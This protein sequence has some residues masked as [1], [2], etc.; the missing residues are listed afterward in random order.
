MSMSKYKQLVIVFHVLNMTVSVHISENQ[1]VVSQS[2]KH[3][4]SDEDRKTVAKKRKRNAGADQVTKMFEQVNPCMSCPQ[5]WHETGRYFTPIYKS[6]G[7]AKRAL[8]GSGLFFLSRFL[9]GG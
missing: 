1:L 9:S 7:L 3:R 8:S 2:R 4:V 6:K 5:S